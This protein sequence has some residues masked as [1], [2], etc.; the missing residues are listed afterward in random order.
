MGA[1][2]YL[3]IR[4]IIGARLLLAIVLLP[5]VMIL[6]NAYALTPHGATGAI[7][8]PGAAQ[9]LPW[10]SFAGRQSCARTPR[11]TD[12]DC[13]VTGSI[14]KRALAP[15]RRIEHVSHTA[16]LILHFTHPDESLQSMARRYRA[17]ASAIETITRVDM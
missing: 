12:I 11:R 14:P 2:M 8:S 16:K 6:A 7:A 4:Q 3:S 5:A 10:R 13:D 9:A 1:I 15:A 17:T